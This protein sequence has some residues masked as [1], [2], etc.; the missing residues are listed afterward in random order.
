MD[1]KRVQ[2]VVITI[3]KV[4]DYIPLVSSETNIVSLVIKVT[5]EIFRIINADFHQKALEQPL[6]KHY[7]EKKLF[8]CIGLCIPVI[9]T[10]IALERDF[11]T[12]TLRDRRI[13]QE[14]LIVSLEGINQGIT[15]MRNRQNYQATLNQIQRDHEAESKRKEL[16]RKRK[17][18]ARIQAEIQEQNNRMRE[19]RDEQQ[20]KMYNLLIFSLYDQLRILR[21]T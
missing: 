3:D 17:E 20:R 6:V 1:L 18:E 4:C 9:N 11:P 5:L 7:H 19:C 2:E 12:P 8:V 10:I 15:N 16:E 13:T 14:E 21:S